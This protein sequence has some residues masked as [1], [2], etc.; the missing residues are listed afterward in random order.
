[1]K[2][3]FNMLVA[4]HICVCTQLPVTLI[5]VAY[6]DQ[7]EKK[8]LKCRKQR[9]V[10]ATLCSR[11]CV[12]LH[13]SESRVWGSPRTWTLPFLYSAYS[14]HLVIVGEFTRSNI[15]P[16][17]TWAKRQV[18]L[19]KPLHYEKVVFNLK[20]QIYKHLIHQLPMPFIWNKQ[21]AILF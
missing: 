19:I 18:F 21:P 17:V 3:C 5:G 15:W 16:E 4:K 12:L 1:M 8:C 10:L 6:A 7:P 9:L 2:G 13:R 20:T 11:E 14:T